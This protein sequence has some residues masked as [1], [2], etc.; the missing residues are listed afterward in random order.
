MKIFLIKFLILPDPQYFFLL[1]EY[2]ILAV[3]N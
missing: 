3:K 1:H 2:E